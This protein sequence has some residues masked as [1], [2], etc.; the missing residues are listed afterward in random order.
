MDNDLRRVIVFSCEGDRLLGTVDEAGGETGV[1]I[2]S[3]GNEVRCGAHRG[4]AIVADR[5]AAAGVPVFRFDRRGVG[6]SEGE[7]NGYASAAPDIAAAMA[8]FRRE[9]PHVD[10]VIGFG[11]CDAATALLL[12]DPDC[13][14]LVLANPWLGNEA[15]PLPPAAIRATYARKLRS[16]DA[17]RSM[18]RSGLLRRLRDL[19]SILAT[20]TEQPLERRITAA[21]RRAPATVILAAED[22]T[23]QVFAACVPASL[24]ATIVMIATPSHSFAGKT[25]ALAQV[26]LDVV[27]R[28]DAKAV[29]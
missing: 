8:A 20:Q 11:N 22:R 1:L 25:E 28:L 5:L 7:N 17:W 9:Q 18:F 23:A 16:P 12:L 26:L 14:A 4:M 27:A 15:A 19:R 24:C 29:G 10:Q 6:D 13:D 21:L 2:V 3:G